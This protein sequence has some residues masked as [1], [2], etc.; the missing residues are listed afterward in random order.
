MSSGMN[1]SIPWVLTQRHCISGPK[2]SKKQVVF[3]DWPQATR[4]ERPKA[5]KEVRYGEGV[6]PSP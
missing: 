6:S 4:V 2:K 5:T 1:H 3:I